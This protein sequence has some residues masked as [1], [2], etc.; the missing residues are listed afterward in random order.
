MKKFDFVLGAVIALAPALALQ[1]CSHAPINSGADAD[2]RAL[3]AQACEA[4]AGVKSVKGS[5]WLKAKSK[6]A[7]G[8]FPAEVAAPSADRVRLEVT[9]PLGG[10]E[11][12]L[13]VEGSHYKIQVPNHKERNERGDRSWGGIPLEWANALFLGRIPCPDASR[14][15]DAKLSRG[16]AGELVVETP[17]TLDRLPE[18]YVYRMRAIDGGFWAESLHWERQ[19]IAGS[20]PVV[21][22][23]KF[24]DP[25]SKTRSPLK[26]EAKG[27]QGEVKVRWKDRQAS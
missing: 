7:S 23:F 9:N 24:D 12:V 22:D 11:A 27:A 16:P 21:V 10:T 6:E 14:A 20:A 25:D 4:G 8:Q 17:K 2:P 15:K 3:L 5:V 19:G 13:S 18:K 26:W 1:G